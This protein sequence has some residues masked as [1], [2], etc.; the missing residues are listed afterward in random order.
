MN[1][2]QGKVAANAARQIPESR[3][4]RRNIWLNDSLDFERDAPLNQDVRP[5]IEDIFS[6]LNL[7]R[8]KKKQKL[9]D[10]LHILIENLLIDKEKPIAIPMSPNE[11]PPLPDNYEPWAS[12]RTLKLI[13]ALEEK[14]MIERE[15]GYQGDKAKNIPGR[16]TRIWPT[17]LLL[18]HF[19]LTR[20]PYG[21]YA[22][23]QLI[24]LKDDD[25]RLLGYRDTDKTIRI[26][27][28]LTKANEVNAAHR[29]EYEGH[30]ISAFLYAIFKGS[31]NR[32]GRMHSRGLRHYQG[33]SGSQRKEFTI[34]D[35]SVIELDF[36]GYQ[37]RLLYALEGIQFDEDP[38]SMINPEPMAR[39][40]LKKIL[41]S[42]INS[43][44]VKKAQ[45]AAN[46]WLLDN[47]KDRDELREIGITRARP[48]I[49]SF[50]QTHAPIAHY[51]CNSK[52]TG[53]K[54]MT[55]DAKIALDVIKHF[56]FQ[57]K[58]ILPVHDSFIVQ[59]C[60]EEEL[61]QTMLKSYSKHTGGFTCPIK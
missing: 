17:S 30:R 59:A 45:N 14:G 10:D 52:S 26:R 7:G 2:F 16:I 38:Y 39:P 32:Y 31:F 51:F 23:G 55:L 8:C 19:P 20:Q 56:A 21:R 1:V 15:K 57:D 53:M 60:Y 58:V 42:L 34:N 24:I 49:D 11:W 13:Y 48:L 28:I 41:L 50:Y 5:I 37:P 22:T 18:D 33:Y 36:S 61:R 12:Q 35:Q 4:Q 3:Q 9:I 44:D 27:K 25:G 47:K 54:M 40:F 29:I 43:T 6:G 46:K